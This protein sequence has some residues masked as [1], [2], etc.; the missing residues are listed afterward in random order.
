VIGSYMYVT[1][2]HSADKP[3]AM[4][5][6]TKFRRN[7]D[8][9]HEVYRL[10]CSQCHTLDGYL[11]LRR[12]VAGKSSNTIEGV[13]DRMATWRNRRMPPFH[14]T[15]EEKRALAVYLAKLG[16][17]RIDPPKIV[18][19]THSGAE[20]FEHYC[21]MCHGAQGDWP[22]APRVGKRTA[23]DI[24]ALIGELPKRNDM[25]LPF[26]GTDDERRALASY[27]AALN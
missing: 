4:L 1:G 23:P 9:G 10:L 11:G 12:L 17:G 21:A 7:A 15:P 20:V 2:I 19:T 6:S 18:A 14:G 3:T 5:V 22:I 25:M 13:V 16:G 27:L 8:D 26:E 24:Y